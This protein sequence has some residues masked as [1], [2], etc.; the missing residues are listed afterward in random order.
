MT[1]LEKEQ[2][3]KSTEKTSRILSFIGMI[4]A[5]ICVLRIDT[6]LVNNPRDNMVDAAFKIFSAPITFKT[7][8]IG[9]MVAAFVPIGFFLFRNISQIEQN[10][11]KHDNPDTVNGDAHFMTETELENY[12][13]QKCTPIGKPGMEGFDDLIFSKNMRL[14]VDNKKTRRNCNTTCIGGSGAGKSFFFAGPNLL[15]ARHNIIVTDPSGELRRDYAK[16][17]ENMGYEILSFDTVSIYNSNRYNP[18]AYIYSEKDIFIMVNTLIKNTTPQPANKAGD[19]FWENGEKMLL[20]AICLYLWHTAE[21]EDQTFGNVL[22]LLSLAEIDENDATAKSPLDVLFDKLEKDDPENLAVLQY[23][24]FKSGAG[25]TM[26]SFLIS[27]NAR[28][29]KF[30]LSEMKYLTSKDDFHFENFADSKKALFIIVPTADDTFR[31]IVSQLYSQLFMVLYNYAET[32]A[33]YG[34]KATLN[35]DFI[36]V[37]QASNKKESKQAEAEIRRFKQYCKSGL[38][39]RKNNQKK[40]YEVV[41]EKTGEVVAWR[42][43]RTD[44]DYLAKHLQ[45]VVIEKCGSSCPRY[46]EFILDEFANVGQIPTF[47]EKVATIRKYNI[48]VFIILQSLSQLKKLYKDEWNELVGNCDIKLMLGTDDPETNKYVVENILGK[49][50]TIVMNRSKN[51]KGEISESFNRSQTDLMTVTQLRLMDENDCIVSV[52]GF[53]PCYDKKYKTTSHPMYPYA[54]SLSNQYT[55]EMTEEAK[56][57]KAKNDGPLRLRKSRSVLSAS[58]DAEDG[59]TDKTAPTINENTQ[60][61]K[62]LVPVDEDRKKKQQSNKMRIK[63]AEEEE[64]EMSVEDIV[65]SNLYEP[66]S[67]DN[68]DI[69]AM[70]L[71]ESFGLEP[72]ASDEAI[73]EAVETLVELEEHSASTIKY[74]IT[75]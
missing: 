75:N 40:Y 10:L 57:L 45:D 4:I 16:Y 55:L 64:V 56:L 20:E 37:V 58:S 18:F 53:P 9:L 44:A 14:S 73:E 21:P 52:K 42:G 59:V 23:K 13:R 50:T 49:R 26:K 61:P 74:G 33:C 54:S 65:S 68:N 72:G 15:Q 2:M 22:R 29:E 28:L 30:E 19:P 35:N 36:K 25:K 38:I 6:I 48:C 7:D 62:P 34:Y 8:T 31:F 32:R 43:R 46:I 27:V 3:K 67:D 11:N 51:A 5:C 47:A 71:L 66:P 69:A 24:K 12:Q 60:P 1:N 17:L 39:V 41:I 70:S 63:H